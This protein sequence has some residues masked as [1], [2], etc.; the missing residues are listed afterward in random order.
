MCNPPP[1]PSYLLIPMNKLHMEEAEIM[2]TF[3]DAAGETPLLLL[4]SQ[5]RGPAA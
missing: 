2:K 3:S 4:A 5:V 1:I